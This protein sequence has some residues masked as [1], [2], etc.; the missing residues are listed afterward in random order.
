MLCI[1]S[2]LSVES[3]YRFK[4]VCKSILSRI[5]Q[6]PLSLLPCLLIPLPLSTV[7]KASPFFGT[8]ISS[9]NNIPMKVMR[10]SEEKGNFR[11]LACSN[12]MV[13]YTNH[14]DPNIY[15]CNHVTKEYV[16]LPEGHLAENLCYLVPEISGFYFDPV[17]HT[18]NLLVYGSNNHAMF[19]FATR[20]WKGLPMPIFW[21]RT[22]CVQGT[23]YHVFRERGQN[24][25]SAI[26]RH[27]IWNTF[28]CH[29]KSLKTV[30]TQYKNCWSGMVG[31]AWFTGLMIASSIYGADR[32]W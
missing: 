22:I 21:S 32:G 30:L 1:L 9:S 17:N 13:C 18:F 29:C 11:Q 12:G 20:H 24:L 3:I 8:L 5:Y 14:G 4:C 15:I 6:N 27:R 19:S 16:T 7:V 23:C 2:A 10:P 25:L 26:W 28:L 31:C